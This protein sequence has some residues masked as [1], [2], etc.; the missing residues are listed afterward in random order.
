MRRSFRPAAARAAGRLRERGAPPELHPGRRRDRADAV[1]GEPADRRRSRSGSASRCSAACT[2]RCALTEDG[3]TLLRRASRGAEP[4][5]SAT[6]EL[7]HSERA[8]DGRRHDDAGL[9]RSLADPAPGRLR[10]RA[11]RRRRAHLGRQRAR[12]PRPRRRRRRRPLPVGRSAGPGDGVRLFGETVL[13]VCSP[14]LRG[15]PHPPLVAARRSRRATRCC[16][17]SP[18]AATSCRTGASGCTR[19]GSAELHPAGVLHFSSYDQLISAAL[20]GQG[21]ALGRVPLIDSQ[22]KSRKLV[23]PFSDARRLAAQLLHAGAQAAAER[24]EVREFMAWLVALQ[25][26]PRVQHAGGVERLL[27]ARIMSSAT[28]DLRAPARR[29]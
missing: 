7:R 1:G 3:R 25:H 27:I 11:S 21:V 12:Q 23:A 13:P 14:R 24:P 17:W 6:R 22:L 4:A 16:A 20:A 10:R 15:A 29:A 9:R 18:T 19:W 5:R 26:A 8:Q 2:V 28:G